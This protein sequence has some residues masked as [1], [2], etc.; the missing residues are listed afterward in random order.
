MINYRDTLLAQYANSPTITALVDYADQWFAPDDTLDALYDNV[1]NVMTAQGFGLDI[2]GRI[3]GV[4]REL[5]IP[6]PGGFF[7]WNDLGFGQGVF[8]SGVSSSTM[9]SLSD[10]AYRRVILATAAAN[11]SPGTVP[12]INAILRML[13]GARVWCQDNYDM[14]MTI[15]TNGTLDVTETAILNAGIIPRPAGVQLIVT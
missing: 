5:N 13:F 8:Y 2:W 11:I 6:V 10:D 1:I 9:F 15:V 7:G 4:G 14:T 12:S 3:V